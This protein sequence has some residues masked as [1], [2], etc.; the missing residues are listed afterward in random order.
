MVNV[1]KI[2]NGY[3]PPSIIIYLFFF[4]NVLNIR[5]FQII[6]NDQCMKNSKSWIRNGIIK[7]NS[8]LGKFTE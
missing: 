1:Y 3:A 6:S 4:E 2:I 8:P 5:N 7:N